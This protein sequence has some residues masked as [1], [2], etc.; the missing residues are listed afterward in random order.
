MYEITM[1]ERARGQS[2]QAENAYDFIKE[3]AV[4][5]GGNRRS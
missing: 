5:V 4:S 2:I 3:H 1:L